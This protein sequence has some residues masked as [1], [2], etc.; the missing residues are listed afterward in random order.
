MKIVKCVGAGKFS[1][2]KRQ[3]ENCIKCP[4]YYGINPEH[5]QKSDYAKNN[6]VDIFGDSYNKCIMP[7]ENFAWYIKLVSNPKKGD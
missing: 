5:Y 3:K 7:I 2:D 1:I 4:L 6:E